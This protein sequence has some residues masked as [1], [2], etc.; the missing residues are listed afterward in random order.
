MEI[1]VTC[2]QVYHDRCPSV[3]FF[4]NQTILRCVTQDESH[5]YCMN[6]ITYSLVGIIVDQ[7]Q[8]QKYYKLDIIGPL[9]FKI[10]LR[11]PGNVTNEANL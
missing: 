9:Y 4:F 5:R 11:F 3:Q 6:F 2:H 10:H 7:L 1:Q 8:Q